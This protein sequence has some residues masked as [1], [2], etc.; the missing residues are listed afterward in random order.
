MFQHEK[1]LSDWPEAAPVNFLENETSGLNL[2]VYMFQD[3]LNLKL[4]V[5]MSAPAY[6]IN[7][8]IYS[9]YIHKCGDS[10]GN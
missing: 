8:Y 6:S 2:C 1:Q 7:I 4:L 3:L 5:L 9:I 10:G